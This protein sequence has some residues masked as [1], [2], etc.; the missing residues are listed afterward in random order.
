MRIVE[1]TYN[2]D[3]II[4]SGSAS[5]L[6]LLQKAYPKLEILDCDEDNKLIQAAETA[7]Y[8]ANHESLETS[9]NR[10]RVIRTGKGLT[11]RALAE[12]TGV[13]REAISML[14]GGKRALGV[15]LAKKLAPGLGI[16]YK[17]LL[18]DA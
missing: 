9:A 18:P 10:L 3:L 7:L 5:L 2:I 15:N 17:Q 4:R 6:P 13:K 8:S 12:A 11:Q 14:E 1:R 16:E